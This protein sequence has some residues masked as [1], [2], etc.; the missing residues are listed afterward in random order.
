MKSK[1]ITTVSTRNNEGLRKLKYSLDHFG[2]DYEI[3]VD[4][5]IGWDWG[6]WRNVYNY[7]KS[8]RG[9]EYTHLIYTDGFDTLALAPQSEAEAA[10]KRI[11]GDDI[12]KFIYSTEKNYFPGEEPEQEP[13]RNW[14]E[15]FSDSKLGLTPNHRWR[16][17][18]GGQYAG[19]IERIIEWYDNAPKHLNNQYWANKYYSMHNDGRLVL[20]FNC[21]LFQSVAFSGPD[22]NAMDEFNFSTAKEDGR[23]INNLIGTRPVFAHA[24]GMKGEDFKKNFKFVY[25]ILG[26]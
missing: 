26:I 25:D 2:Y 15:H 14:N 9:S 6:G 16:Y 4:S 23:L 13:T 17:V 21:E 1:V 3:L 20:D 11:C 24:N 5:S 10:L 18:N 7:A 22:H 19:S 12:N 8:L